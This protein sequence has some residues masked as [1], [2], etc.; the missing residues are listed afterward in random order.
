MENI[1]YDYK[2]AKVAVYGLSPLT[3]VLLE[4]LSD[5][6]V[7]GLLDGYQTS[8]SLYGKPI[9]SMD[10]VIAEGV[11]LII[12]AARPESCKIIAKRI[13]ALCKKNAV[14]LIDIHGNDLN[15]LKKA[16]YVFSD[17]P[18][19]T[20]RDLLGLI[21]SH[22]VISVDLFDTLVMRRTLFPAD[23]YEIVDLR[24]QEKGLILDNFPKRR[25]EAEKELCKTTVPTLLE[26]YQYLLRNDVAAS[27]QAE[28][29][30]QIEWETDCSLAV[31]REELCG[32][33]QAAHRNGKPVYIVSDTFY[34]KVQLAA[35]LE[36]CGFTGYRD[37]LTSCEYRT[38][39]NRRLFER[40]REKIP[41]RT[42]L[43]IGD[44]VDADV[45]GAEKNGYTACRLYSGLELFEKV[46]YLG[47][48]ERID[49]LSDRI[50]AGMLVAKLFNSP[51][52]FEEPGCR[53]HVDAAYDVGYLFFGPV[54]SGFVIWL[55]REIH[56]Q[57]LK[58][59]WFGAR[60]GYLIKKLYEQI[61]PSTNSI[62]LLTSRSAAIRA[63]VERE[64]DIRYVEEMRFSGSLQEQLRERFSIS[65][66]EDG[67]QSRLL[68][69]KEE[70]LEAAK[71]S[72]N[73]YLQYMKRLKLAEGDVAFYDFVARGTVQMYV[74]RLTERHLKGFYFWQQDQELMREKGLDIQSYFKPEE[75]AISHYY[76]VLENVLMAPQPSVLGFDETGEACF[77]EETRT[78]RE[79]RCIR[80]V[81]DG[82]TDYF[83]T[84]LTLMP[85]GESGEG[86]ALEESIL[87][88]I[89]EIEIRDTSFLALRD[90][91]LFF[92]RTTAISDLI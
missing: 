78:K 14:K 82:I 18:G 88:L 8:G 48:W 26:I 17:V 73:G 27:V 56:T 2:N 37:I 64:E 91:D 79:L 76:L 6:Q 9:L 86:K 23:V 65:I 67:A 60:D 13:G 70:I 75:S 74:E 47:L 36:R 4:R 30:V 53:L 81:Q 45:E 51:F 50:Q 61:D 31:P 5:Y 84:Y 77:A 39:K 89:R 10:E 85:G 33:L 68:D 72:R 43:H 69:Y 22:D 25:L 1:L 20:K 87:S 15:A 42:C 59:I 34:T 90:E 62:Y 32:L 92:H 66:E 52:Q 54:I 83:R 38:G 44:S 57:G 19:V 80:R 35:M 28:M 7:I 71:T 40:L 11:R 12:V 55:R 29:L 41:G 63:G 16:A 58:N 3:A 21:D 46:G 24:L 49:S